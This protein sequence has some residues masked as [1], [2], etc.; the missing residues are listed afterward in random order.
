MAWMA[1]TTVPA[2]CM[3][4]GPPADRLAAR[5]SLAEESRL[6][7]KMSSARESP[8]LPTCVLSCNQT[9]SGIFVSMEKKSS[10]PAKS[11]PKDDRAP[12]SVGLRPNLP[13]LGISCRPNI[14]D[15]MWALVALEIEFHG[16][17]RTGQVIHHQALLSPSWRTYANTR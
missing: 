2:C 4:E 6:R 9:G 12:A 3:W 15:R 8:P 11:K 14:F 13:I 16:L 7:D 17:R 10:N 1:C 5:S